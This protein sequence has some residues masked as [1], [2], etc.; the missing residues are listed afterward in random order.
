M[1][2]RVL[3]HLT[4]QQKYNNGASLQLPINQVRKKKKGI[5]I[6]IVQNYYIIKSTISTKQKRF[7]H[8]S[9]SIILPTLLRTMLF[10]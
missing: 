3:K 6:V 5:V 2:Y 1:S 9:E 7:N 4:Q 10:N 8:I